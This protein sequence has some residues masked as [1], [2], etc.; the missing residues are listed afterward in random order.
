MLL[1]TD[2][3]KRWSKIRRA[4]FHKYPT[5][6]FTVGF[7]KY[8]ICQ[9][10]QREEG[11]EQLEASGDRAELKTALVEVQRHELQNHVAPSLLFLPIYHISQI[12]TLPG[13]HSR[14]KPLKT[15]RKSLFRMG[16]T[17]HKSNGITKLDC[18]FQIIVRDM[19]ANYH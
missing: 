18:V 12:K 10:S 5:P 7:K 8:H 11:W 19:R 9:I 3:L 4:S 16:N 2:P 15:E 13:F 6:S 17:S 14:K 1:A